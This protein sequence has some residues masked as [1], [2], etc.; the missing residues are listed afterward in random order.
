MIVKVFLQLAFH[1]IYNGIW[2]ECEK[3]VVDTGKNPAQKSTAVITQENE[4]F[5][6]FRAVSAILGHGCPEKPE[7]SLDGE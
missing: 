6:M 4:I 5:L 1:Y 3:I 7:M 2:I